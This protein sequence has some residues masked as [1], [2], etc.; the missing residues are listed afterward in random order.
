MPFAS[1]NKIN[2]SDSKK[3][4]GT[5]DDNS[6]LKHRSAGLQTQPDVLEQTSCYGVMTTVV[7]PATIITRQQ[8]SSRLSNRTDEQQEILST[9]MN[10][11]DEE[12]AGSDGLTIHRGEKSLPST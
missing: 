9:L 3:V 4:V 6:S 7:P 11:D 8:F 1:R 10:N 2:N 12:N 5:L